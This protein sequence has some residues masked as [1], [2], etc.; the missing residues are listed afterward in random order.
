MRARIRMGFF[1][2]PGRCSAGSDEPSRSSRAPAYF[3]N[4]SP[5]RSLP[6]SVAQASLDAGKRHAG[7]LQPLLVRPHVERQSGHVVDKGNDI[8]PAPLPEVEG[9]HVGAAGVTR[10]DPHQAFSL[11]REGADP[12][13]IVL[14][15]PRA[16]GTR[17]APPQGTPPAHEIARG[18]RHELTRLLAAHRSLR[19]VSY[20]HL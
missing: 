18:P 17:E 12:S 10:V 4:Q 2:C 6:Q 8:H 19:P 15:A 3:S 20:T 13:R 14:A 9:L 11:G 7:T 1:R 16:G 5:I